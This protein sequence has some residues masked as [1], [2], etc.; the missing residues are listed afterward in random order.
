MTKR[1]SGTPTSMR[2]AR[3]RAR[4]TSTTTLGGKA[5]WPPASRLLLEA[6]QALL[7]E[8][9]APLTDDLARRIEARAAMTS[10]GRPSAASRMILARIDVSIR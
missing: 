8:A 7:E 2:A 6:R 10:L 9:L 4:L 1:D 5:G 3:T